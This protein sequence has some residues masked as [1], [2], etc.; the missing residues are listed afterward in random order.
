MT[1]STNAVDG[2]VERLT[3]ERDSFMERTAAQAF[4]TL[5]RF[6]GNLVDYSPTTLQLL[7]EWIDRMGRKG[8]LPGPARAMVIA[9]LGQTFI[10]RHGGYWATQRQGTQQSLG[11]VCPVEGTSGRE[12]FID[13]VAQVNRRLTHGILDSLAFFYLSASVDLHGRS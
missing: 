1:L 7:D 9:F 6:C 11:V 2:A 5:E 10:H 13:V 4:E 12:R 8:P 3:P